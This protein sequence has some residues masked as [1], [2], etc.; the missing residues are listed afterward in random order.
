MDN[1]ELFRFMMWGFGICASGFFVLLSIVVG[2]AHNMTKPVKEIRDAL[3]GTLIKKG[4]ITKIFEME[5]DVKEI[6]KE[7]E[8][9]NAET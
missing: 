4:I 5:E 2:T 1:T 3:I 6:K 7:L 9:Y 8:K